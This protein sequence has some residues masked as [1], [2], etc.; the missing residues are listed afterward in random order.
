MTGRKIAIVIL[1]NAQWP[2]LRRH[3]DRAVAATDLAM[4]GS[5]TQVDVTIR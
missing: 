2:T 1:G 3:V 4:S 5:F